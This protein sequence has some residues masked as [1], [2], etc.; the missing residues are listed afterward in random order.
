[1]GGVKK[2]ERSSLSPKPEEPKPK[3]KVQ[4][5]LSGGGFGPFGFD[6]SSVKLKTT[7][8]R[9]ASTLP[10]DAAPAGSRFDI[11]CTLALLVQLHVH[12]CT[13]VHVYLLHVHCRFL[14]I[15]VRVYML[16]ICTHMFICSLTEPSFKEVANGYTPYHKIHKLGIFTGKCG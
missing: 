11:Q 9:G 6:P 3:Q 15:H 5:Q 2:F 12:A 13:H 14:F 1:M 4:P 10:K 8:R 7:G 16:C